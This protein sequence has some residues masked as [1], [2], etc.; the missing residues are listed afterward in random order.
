MPGG[1]SN[2]VG[3]LGYVGCAEELLQQC[4]EQGL[5]FDH[6]DGLARLPSALHDEPDPPA[7]YPLRFL[8]LVRREASLYW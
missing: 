5:V 3:A 6:A 4:A 1:A 2:P 7:D 8:T